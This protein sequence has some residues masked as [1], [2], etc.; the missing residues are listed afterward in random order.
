MTK[1]FL[2]IGSCDF[3]TLSYMSFHGWNGV[4]M[5][6]IPKY[7]NNIKFEENI[8]Y[9]NAAIYPTDGLATMY[10]ASDEVVEKDSD[11]KGMSTLLENSNVNLTI[12]IE[13]RTMCFDTLFKLTNIDEIDY[14]KIDTEGYDGEVLR[15]FPW[16]R[17]KPKYIKFESEHLVLNGWEAD[18]ME[19]LK[20]NGY[21]VEIDERNWYAIKL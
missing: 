3:D 17:C 18:T 4:V 6:P 5:E 2:E 7:F 1:T 10:M 19:L 16:H 8:H 15:M 14:L 9:V 21:H 13:V 20:V 11:F 12:P